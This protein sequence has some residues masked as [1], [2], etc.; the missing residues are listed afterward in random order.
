[1]IQYDELPFLTEDK[2]PEEIA[3][4]YE[5]LCDKRTIF[6]ESCKN[7]IDNFVPDWAIEDE[8]FDC[9]LFTEMYD[10]LGQPW[11][12][13][14]IIQIWRD[15]NRNLVFSIDGEEVYIDFFRDEE[16]IQIVEQLSKS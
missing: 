13:N 6:R 8:Q 4:L 14:N 15:E 2:T 7:F 9:D 12:R 11:I 10:Q 3:L 5:D 16:L 1:M